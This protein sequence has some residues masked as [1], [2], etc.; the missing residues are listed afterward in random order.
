VFFRQQW[1]TARGFALACDSVRL[2][3]LGWARTS[4]YFAALAV[5]AAASACSL[6]RAAVLRP[7]RFGPGVVCCLLFL[8]QF[9]IVWAY[10]LSGG[11]PLQLWVYVPCMGPVA[12][13]A[14][15]AVFCTRDEEALHGECYATTA[16]ALTVALFLVAVWE[17]PGWHARLFG[18]STF[19]LPIVLGGL[20]AIPAVWGR[21][22]V[23]AA[24]GLLGLFVALS[25]LHPTGYEVPWVRWV[26]AGGGKEHYHFVDRVLRFVGSQR[27]AR[28]PWVWLQSGA[29]THER[30]SQEPWELH[31][32]ALAYLWPAGYLE[33]FP[34]FVDPPPGPLAGI[35]VNEKVLG[36]I[37]EG[38]P[39]LIVATGERIVERANVTLGRHGL[40]LRE[41]A[42]RE[43]WLHG[44]HYRAVL[45]E[46]SR[47]PVSPEPPA[48]HSRIPEAPARDLR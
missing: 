41:V 46:A 35:V 44:R 3:G 11:T 24:L 37:G 6:L 30:G 20:A 38:D 9:G 2:T 7:R 47:A 10:E 39:V 26:A 34:D 17:E 8:I 48:N 29:L 40:R 25:A 19:N 36:M 15:A 12:F 21:Q 33:G 43:A 45:A 1:E 23:S 5:A 42:M 18:K 27:V 14:L 31:S 32:L 28:R 16:A 13:V 4:P 22:A